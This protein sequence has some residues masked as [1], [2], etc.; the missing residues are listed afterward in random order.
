MPALT[1]FGDESG[2]HRQHAPSYAIGCLVIET[3]QLQEVEADLESILKRHGVSDEL[4][5][6]KVS[7]HQQRTDAAVEGLR[8]LF[9]HG[10]RY[11]A[12]VVRKD[13]Y[14]KWRLDREEAFYTTYF[15][16]AKQMAERLGDIDLRIDERVDRYPKRSEVIQIVSN[17]ALRRIE[18]ASNV[19]SVEMVDSKLSRVLQF[20]DV[21]T[22]AV[23]TDTGL[24]LLPTVPVNAGK[25]QLIN[26]AAEMLGWPRLYYDTYPNSLFNLWHF[27]IEFRNFPATRHAV[28]NLGPPVRV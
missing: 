21:L 7:G 1:G 20:A 16:L 2:T 12:I 27:P 13:V 25:R 4:K 28:F 6:T 18:S 9:Q 26:R 10:A 5:W 8:H 24:L 14:Q 19:A 23:N 15:L 11:F 22:G 3:R 17:H